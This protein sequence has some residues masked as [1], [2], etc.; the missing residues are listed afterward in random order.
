MKAVINLLFGL[1]FLVSLFCTKAF[2]HSA[3]T[4]SVFIDTHKPQIE[5]EIYLPLDQLRLADESLFPSQSDDLKQVN[6]SALQDYMQTHV[7]I[8]TQNSQPLTAQKVDDFAIHEFDNVL[9]MVM[10]MQF[11]KP[12]NFDTSGFSLH[13]NAILH[14]VVTHKIYVSYR[15]DMHEVLKASQDIATIGLIRYQRETLFI[16]PEK[17]TAWSQFKLMFVNGMSHIAAG[18][19]HL[20]FLLCLILPAPL[21]SA[22]KRWQSVAPVRQC[23]MSVAKIVTFF[24]LGHSL[25]LALTTL[26]YISF[27][28]KPIEILVAA[29]ILVSALNAIRPIFSQSAMWI[30][31]IFGL[32]HGQ[33]FAIEMSHMGFDTQAIIVALVA[34]N[35]GIETVQLLIVICVVPVLAM[36]ARTYFYSAIRITLSVLAM[37]AASYWIIERSM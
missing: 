4:S 15:N 1:T 24:T 23:V 22:N 36:L 35:L 30:A 13:Y 20:L 8:T 21:V 6:F 17:I 3:S 31:F 27:P 29:S 16:E 26:G 2:A 37:A 33:A 9:F 25:T 12:D 11:I 28:A 5:L 32:I 14:R 34:F 10:K 18:I 19:D 7:S